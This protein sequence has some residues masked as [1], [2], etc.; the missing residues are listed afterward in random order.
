MPFHRRAS[1]RIRS[2][3][4]ESRQAVHRA[5]M[6]LSQRRRR[7]RPGPAAD[8]GTSADR[9]E[10]THITG[11]PPFVN[12]PRSL[13]IRPPQPSVNPQSEP[14][15]PST[16]G[17]RAGPSRDS[18]YEKPTDERKAYPPVSPSHVLTPKSEVRRYAPFSSQQAMKEE[19][20]RNPA[21]NPEYDPLKS[22]AFSQPQL[23][24]PSHNRHFPPPDSSGPSPQTLQHYGGRHLPQPQQ[25]KGSL[26]QG[27]GYT[28]GPPP[29]SLEGPPPQAPRGPP[30]QAPKGTPSQ[31]P[32]EPAS[33]TLRGPQPFNFRGIPSHNPNYSRGPPPQGPSYAGSP[34][35]P[36][37]S[38]RT[39]APMPL[40]FGG[41]F[42]GN[43]RVYRN[44]DTKI[45]ETII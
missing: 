35:N 15:A 13:R 44:P 19:Q 24:V 28:R 34:R 9:P 16:N 11:P 2:S 32:R 45:D 30:P 26:H 41:N 4:R 14:P 10:V 27:Y 8:T 39:R 37:T 38:S 31:A 12:G 33:H 22:A 29:Q 18:A 43:S 3:F 42:H 17:Y 21:F 25:P 40:G 20:I 1:T 5:S 23:H 6:R 7:P 36:V